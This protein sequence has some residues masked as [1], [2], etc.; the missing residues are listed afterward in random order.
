ME[1]D[2]IRQSKSAYAC[3]FNMIKNGNWRICGEFRKLNALTIPNR[4]PLPHMQDCSHGIAGKTIFT[5]IDLD[6]AYHQIPIKTSD[7]PKTAVITPIGLF[8]CT[9]MTFGLRNAAQS[10]QR[11]IDQ[12]LLGLDCYAYLDDI[13][14]ASEDEEKHKIDLE[15][16]F[17][18]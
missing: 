9:R 11:Y 2:I 8:E 14:V 10:F 18:G 5:K 7:I 15:R 4:Y 6:K 3:L 1:Q 13:L 17:Q 16:V 12:V